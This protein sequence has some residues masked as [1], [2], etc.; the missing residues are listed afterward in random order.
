MLAGWQILCEGQTSPDGQASPGGQT[1]TA[2]GQTSQST[3][4]AGS[5]DVGTRTAPAPALSAVAGVQTEAGP[6]ETSSGLPQIPALLGGAGVTGAF[7]SEM[8]RS[9]YLR[10][11]VNVGATY[12]TNPLLLSGDAV[13]NGSVSIFPNIS[14]QESTTRTRWTVGYAGGLTVNQR[15]TNQDEGSHNLNFDSQFRLS[16]HVNLRVAENFSLTTGF[17]DAGNGTAIVAVASGPDP[18]LISPLST[19]RSNLTTVEM[20]YHFALNE[21]VGASGSFYDLHLTNIP[22]GTPLTELTNSQ[23]ATGSAFWL[24]RIIGDDWGGLTYRF[25]RIT[26]NPGGGE[27][28]VHSFLAVDT[29]NISKRFTLT[30]FIGPQYLENQGLSPGGLPVEGT[31]NSNNWSLAG[32][33]EV[34]WRNVRNNLSAGFSRIISDGGGV[35]GTVRLQ[36]VHGDYR[37]QLTRAWIADV[38]AAYGK[39]QSLIV[40]FATSATSIDLTSAGFSL[41]RNVNKSFGLHFGYR[42]DF[43]QQFGVPGLAPSSLQT[44]DASRN[45]VFVTFSYQWLKPL[46]M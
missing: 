5:G 20:N 24:R 7:L 14:I 33:A 3:S 22:T 44:L 23:T 40:P 15:F 9:N 39:N 10:G 37:R 21:L 46:G 16:P 30:G 36:T 1:Q 35:L 43:Q 6:D 19:E 45:L 17:F 41:E 31:N 11:G 29:L 28:L 42:H 4:N 26:F 38:S 8:E 25:Q 27:T 2:A 12:D 34:G 32:G 13:G 18:S